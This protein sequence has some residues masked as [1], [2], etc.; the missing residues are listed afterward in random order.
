MSELRV[1]TAGVPASSGGRKGSIDGVRRIRE[2]GLD[3]MEVEF[4]QGILGVMS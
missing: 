2:L 3:C 1:G 4:V